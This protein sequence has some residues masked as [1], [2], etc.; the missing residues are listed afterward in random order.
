MTLC[1][2]LPNLTESGKPDCFTKYVEAAL[3]PDTSAAS[4]V[5]TFNTFNCMVYIPIGVTEAMVP[6]IIQQLRF[7]NHIMADRSN[8]PKPSICNPKKTR[9]EL[10]EEEDEMCA[11]IDEI[12][13]RQVTDP[14]V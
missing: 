8:K 1:L 3:M 14:N 5:D 9:Q 13:R 7:R 12:E 4:I 6:E 11:H 10:E 2:T